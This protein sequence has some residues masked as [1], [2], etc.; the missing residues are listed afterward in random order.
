MMMKYSQGESAMDAERNNLISGTRLSS[1]W[2]PLKGKNFE[3]KFIW[4]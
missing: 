4:R 1:D 2:L 3:Q